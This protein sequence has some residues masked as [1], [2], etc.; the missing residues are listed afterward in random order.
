MWTEYHTMILHDTPEVIHAKRPAVFIVMRPRGLGVGVHPL[1]NIPR[2]SG[3]STN[4]HAVPLKLPRNQFTQVLSRTLLALDATC[5][6]CNRG[7][8]R[9]SRLP[10]PGKLPAWPPICRRVD[11]FGR[12][13]FSSAP[14]GYANRS[15]PANDQFSLATP[16]T[17]PDSHRLPAGS[18]GQVSYGAS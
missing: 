5:I 9:T 3:V 4:V 8:I 17:A 11:Y 6:A 7:S 18:T 13:T 10:P 16:Q 14:R 15:P 1:D 2:Q 12:P